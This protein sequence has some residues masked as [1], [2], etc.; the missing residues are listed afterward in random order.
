MTFQRANKINLAITL[1]DPASIGSEIIL[2]ALADNNFSSQAHIT[3]IGS[4]SSLKKAYNDLKN[5]THINLANPDE[6]N[7]IDMIT[8]SDLIWGKGNAETGKASFLYL[9]KSIELTLDGKFDGIVTAPIAKY[10]W[11]EA[12]Y[13][14]AG[15]TEVLAQKSGIDKFAMMFIGKSPYTGW[16]LRTLLATTHIPLKAVADTLN[17]SLMDAKLELL[18]HTLKQDFNLANP[19][20]AIAGLNPH[21]GEEGK[22]GTEEKDWLNDWL[23]NAKKRYPEAKLTGLTPPDT[24]WVKPAQAW[25]HDANIATADGFL[26]L[27]HDQGLIPVKSMAFDRAVNTTIGLPFVRT[28]PDHGTA[29]DIAGQGIANP[30]SMIASIEWSIELCRN[31]KIVYSL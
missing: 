5:H 10:L 20:I 23:D 17:P 11:Q 2:K 16:M 6:L 30:S 15:Q 18:I 29:F 28:S 27:Y 4:R 7:V 1:G 14:Y 21:S 12:G 26:A 9:E 25:Y 3:I 19:H 8:P 24:L 13:N 22:L 31:R